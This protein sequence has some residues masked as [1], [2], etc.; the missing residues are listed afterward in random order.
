[1]PTPTTAEIRTWAR[2]EGLTVAERGRLAP[3]VLKAYAAAHKK[4]GKPVEKPRSNPSSTKSTAKKPP[5][6]ATR[7]KKR[8]AAGS[9]ASSGRPPT[10][11]R[12][13]ESNLPTMTSPALPTTPTSAGSSEL[14]K[15]EA[16]EKTVSALV[17]RVTALEARKGEKKRFARKS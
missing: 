15:I 2:R 17:A 3:A 11:A 1:M 9:S 5:A 16:L 4:A 14:V 8:Q 7:P 6:V 10:K 12:M 13:V